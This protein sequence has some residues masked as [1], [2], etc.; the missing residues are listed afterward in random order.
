MNL[1]T[2]LEKF[3]SGVRWEL[4]HGGRIAVW[5]S[6]VQP[7]L[8]V[9]LT[10][11]SDAAKLRSES[12]KHE[13]RRKEWVAARALSRHLTG[14]EPEETAVGYPVWPDSWLGSI[15]HKAGHVALWL[16]QNPILRCGIDLEESRQ[17]ELEM[18]KKIMNDHEIGL[19]NRFIGINSS[20][21]VFS[22]KEAVYK[23]LCP[24]VGRKF[25]F[26]AVYLD[27]VAGG[28]DQFILK[29]IVTE[30]LS[31]LVPKGDVI[32]VAAK[33]ISLANTQHWLTLAFYQSYGQSTF[34]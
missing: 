31:S 4:L 24:L 6:S 15:S 22:A 5:D 16:A 1:I 29:F 9:L 32:N 30:R 28:G 33:S 14:Y 20:S 21:L 10:G 8:D 13:A 2:E 12:I 26:E 23:A 7:S 18:S 11:V 25:Y 19:A 27:D 3:V 34:S 17:F